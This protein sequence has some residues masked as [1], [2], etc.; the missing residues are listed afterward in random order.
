MNKAEAQIKFWGDKFFAHLLPAHRYAL[1]AELLRLHIRD[2]SRNS[3]QTVP[4]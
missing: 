3:R 2:N 4:S 1:V